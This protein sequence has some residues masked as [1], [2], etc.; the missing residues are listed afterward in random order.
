MLIISYD[1]KSDKL[2]TRF[3][4]FIQKYGERIQYSV[5][6]IDNSK[7]ILENIKIEVANKFEKKFSQADSVWIFDASEDVIKW[8]YAK[9]FDS[10]VIVVN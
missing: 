3:S 6:R 5:F 1:I 8:G 2:R 10:D 4:K 9:D 7:R